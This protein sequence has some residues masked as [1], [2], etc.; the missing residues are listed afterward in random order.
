MVPR[1]AVEE[2]E[3]ATLTTEQE[4]PYKPE[5]VQKDLGD[6]PGWG[7]GKTGPLGR[8]YFNSYGERLNRDRVLR[9][10]P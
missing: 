2:E 1:R 6:R 9:F 4:P 10:S 7:E 3:G 5:Q 8:P